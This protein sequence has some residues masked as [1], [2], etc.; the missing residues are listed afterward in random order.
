MVDGD[1]S[2]AELAKEKKAALRAQPVCR[3]LL[4]PHVT[5]G[6]EAIALSTSREVAIPRDPNA[7]ADRLKKYREHFH[8]VWPADPWDGFAYVTV[9]DPKDA[10]AMVLAVARAGYPAMR[11]Q[12]GTAT[13]DVVLVTKDPGPRRLVIEWVH[14]QWRISV[15][16]GETY[17]ASPSGVASACPKLGRCVDVVVLH[18][19]VLDEDRVWVLSRVLTSPPLSIDKPPV[20][21]ESVV[22]R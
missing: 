16:D 13:A 4:R 20:A 22:D 3:E 17:D 7:L 6:K 1:P 2:P 19:D 9:D 15:A 5:V 14:K 12:A 8:S 21:L 18:D 11:I 10:R